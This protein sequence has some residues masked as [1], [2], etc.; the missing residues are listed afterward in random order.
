MDAT[1]LLRP[2]LLAG[3]VIALGGGAAL[4]EPLGAL[5]AT[6]IPLPAT[7]DEEEAATALAARDP[8]DV[9]V[10]DLRPAFMG[11]DRLRAA[12]DTAWV[13]VRAVAASAFVPDARDGQVTLIAPPPDAGDPAAAGV[14]A[15]AENLAR[16]LSIEWARHGVRTVAVLP[17]A[18][19]TDAE[20]GALAA[21]L[22]SPA[23]DYFSGCAL[24]LGAT[25]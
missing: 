7:C 4:G 6:L 9:L 25:M 20:L 14:R 12:L 10:H 22:A 19:T 21:Y 15:A 11:E 13:T 3:R 2:G 1:A 23:G 8:V 18:G 24:T 16:T 5:G 17:A